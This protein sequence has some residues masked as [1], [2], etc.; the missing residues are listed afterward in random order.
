MI[1][2]TSRA[3]AEASGR[4]SSHPSEI[5]DRLY[6][7][8]VSRQTGRTPAR[9]RF[10]PS[11]D[12]EKAAEFEQS[13]SPPDPECTFAPRVNPNYDARPVRARYMDPTPKRKRFGDAT[14]NHADCTFVPKV[15]P[16]NAS[17]M[18][19]A[20][21]YVSLDSPRPACVARRRH[22][23]FSH[24]HSICC[25]LYRSRRP[26]FSALQRRTR[27]RTSSVS[28]PCGMT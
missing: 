1:N 28:V 6:Q 13:A 7:Q 17:A 10:A 27:R 14:D 20:A 18:P 4:P 16:V 19:A 25:L 24:T 26:C 22:A 23:P 9:G 21:V 12:G 11:P 3:V 2:E 5:Y 15:N 8:A